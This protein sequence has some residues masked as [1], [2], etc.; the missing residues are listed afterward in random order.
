MLRNVCAASL[1]ILLGLSVGV[2][3]GEDP[4]A[5][6]FKEALASPTAE[7]SAGVVTAEQEKHLATRINALQ[8]PF[9]A[10]DERGSKDGVKYFAKTLTGSVLV[11]DQ[12]IMYQIK[13]SSKT[14]PSTVAIKESWIKAKHTEASGLKPSKARFNFF[15][16]SDPKKWQRNVAAFDEVGFGQVY[17]GVSLSLKAYNNNVEKLFSVAGGADPRRIAIRVDGVSDLHINRAGELE[18]LSRDGTLRMT[19]P[20]A[21]QDA[22]GERKFVKAAYN[23][24][25]KNSYGFKVEEYDRSLPL[26]IDPLL[27]STFVGYTGSDFGYAIDGDGSSIYITGST[28]STYFPV[29]DGAA[30]PFQSGGYDVFVTKLKADLQAATSPEVLEASTFIGGSSDDYGTAIVLF[31]DPVA[32]WEVYVAGSTKSGDFPIPLNGPPK[33]FDFRFNGAQD[34]FLCKLSS[35]LTELRTATFLGGTGIDQVYALKPGTIK[36]PDDSTATLFYVTGTTQSKDFPVLADSAFDI[37]YSGST[38]IFVSAFDSELALY[39]STL[40]GG[41]GADVPYALEFKANSVFLAGSTL[42]A[43]FPT[44]P[45]SYRRILNGTKPD[46]FVARLNFSLGKL[47]GSTLLGGATDDAAYALVLA[48]TDDNVTGIYVAGYTNSVN[49]PVSTRYVKGKKLNGKEDGFVAKLTPTLT[50]KLGDKTMYSATFLGGASSDY[51]VAMKVDSNEKLVVAGNTKSTQ[52]TF[53]VT[54]GAYDVLYNGGDD[55]FVMILNPDLCSLALPA[56]EPPCD[57]VEQC[58]YIGGTSDDRP[59]GLYVNGSNIYLVGTTKSTNYPTY[60]NTEGNVP[61]QAIIGGKEDVFISAFET[62]LS[63][64]A[65]P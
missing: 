10:N 50:G 65:T 40:L 27:A 14:G 15:K 11:K 6:S 28:N 22:N 56:T 45:G 37:Y 38:D 13:R 12:G 58:T 55:G 30:G 20:V 31:E 61:Y 41:I 3:A 24:L 48:G 62:D 36:F 32:G 46:A 8:V 54:T 5:G 43:D 23:R 63:A 64:L 51:I 34:G 49:F 29:T 47:E 1:A 21:Y 18:L 35:D 42:S 7:H 16:G 52:T 60:A 26:I 19:A 2:F 25:S 4:V 9:I 44:G 33:M 39:Y 59:V 57:P 17:E 53:P